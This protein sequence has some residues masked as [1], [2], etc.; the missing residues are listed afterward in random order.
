MQA[1]GVRTAPMK[2]AAHRRMAAF[3]MPSPKTAI[4][5]ALAIQNVLPFVARR[6]AR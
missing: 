6:T 3:V 1:F 5:F 4:E 2:K